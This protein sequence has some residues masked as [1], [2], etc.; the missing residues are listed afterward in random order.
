MISSQIN[1]RKY[2]TKGHEQVSGDIL[3][4]HWSSTVKNLHFQEDEE[5]C[6]LS[7]LENTI[8]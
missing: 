4:I 8:K 1:V 5:L 2:R 6:D 7:I 3:M